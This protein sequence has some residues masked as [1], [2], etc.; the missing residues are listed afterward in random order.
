MCAEKD[1]IK[2][3][4]S[5]MLGKGFSEN[6]FDVK[7]IISKDKLESQKELEERLLEMHCPDRFQLTLFDGER[8]GLPGH[9]K[10]KI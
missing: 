4:R 2:C 10:N 3:H 5:I 9:I 6:G 7:H 8:S 1:P